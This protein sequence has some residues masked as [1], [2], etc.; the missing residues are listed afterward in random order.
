MLYPYLSN[1]WHWANQLGP[2]A[3]PQSTSFPTIS[4][5]PQLNL[6]EGWKGLPL[7]TLPNHAHTTFSRVTQT[8]PHH[9]ETAGVYTTQSS[10]RMDRPSQ[11]HRCWCHSA[12]P[13]HF[14]Q[15]P[16]PTL[17]TTTQQ[18]WS[19]LLKDKDRPS[20]AYSHRHHLASPHQFSQGLRPS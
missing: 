4:P 17:K 19:N 9:L 1:A 20:R 3:S 12:S 11:A 8:T 15:G 2:L 18:H 5:I 13:H 16:R 6:P 14:S 10:R 7:P